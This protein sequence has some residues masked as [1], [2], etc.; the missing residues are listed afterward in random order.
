[1]I[2][3]NIREGRSNPSR[4]GRVETLRQISVQRYEC[5]YGFCEAKTRTRLLTAEN[6]IHLVHSNPTAPLNRTLDELCLRFSS[7]CPARRPHLHFRR[8]KEANIERRAKNVL[9]G[10]KV[11]KLRHQCGTRGHSDRAECPGPS[12][13]DPHLPATTQELRDGPGE[14][15]SCRG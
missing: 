10:N 13:S 4:T 11:R 12:P 6:K 3:S 8:Y 9:A 2:T 7:R 5:W 14:R 15:F 1:M